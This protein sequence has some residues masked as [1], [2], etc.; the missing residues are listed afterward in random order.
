MEANEFLWKALKMD[1]TFLLVYSPASYHRCEFY[2]EEIFG[3]VALIIPFDTEEE[4]L[5]IANDTDFGLAAGIFTSDLGK[6]HRFASRLEAGTVFVNTYN[7]MDVGTPFGGF[8]QSGHG[9]ENGKAVIENYS[10]LKA[11]YVNASGK[12]DNPFT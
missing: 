6:A 1:F 12:L 11:V 10:Q 3:P 2:K 7:D 4:A 9:R 5:K 8:K